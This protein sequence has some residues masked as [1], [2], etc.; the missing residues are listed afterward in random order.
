MKTI[1]EY[2]QQ[3]LA[4]LIEHSAK[5]DVMVV[6]TKQTVE[7]DLFYDQELQTLRAQQHDITEILHTL[8]NPSSDAWE[9]IGD[10]G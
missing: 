6:K 10:G 3:L 8:E 4:E 5:I 1:D 2:R 9:N 7:I